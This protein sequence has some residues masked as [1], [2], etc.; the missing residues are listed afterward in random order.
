MYEKGSLG[1]TATL[2]FADRKGADTVMD[3]ATYLALKNDIKLTVLVEGD[4]A[5][6]NFISLIPVSPHKFPRVNYRDTM[7]LV[8]WL[9]SPD[10]GL[11]IIADFGRDRYGTAFFSRIPT[12]GR[13]A[14]PEAGLDLISEN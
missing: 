12:H 5:P 11:R 1:N 3:R 9:T 4:E 13:R 14:V 10:R 8:L 6:L 2:E 7:T